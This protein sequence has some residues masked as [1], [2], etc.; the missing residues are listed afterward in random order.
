[1]PFPYFSRLRC[2]GFAASACSFL[3]ESK[4]VPLQALA[5]L[6]LVQGPSSLVNAAS[7]ALEPI[8][9]VQVGFALI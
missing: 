9:L 8:R 4:T 6:L 5:H 7:V 1:M 3:I 2:R